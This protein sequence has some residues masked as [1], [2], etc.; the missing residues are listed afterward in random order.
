MNG[1][2]SFHFRYDGITSNI[3]TTIVSCNGFGR[4]VRFEIFGLGSIL[5]VGRRLACHASV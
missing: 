4:T 5:T 1:S 3:F 2:L